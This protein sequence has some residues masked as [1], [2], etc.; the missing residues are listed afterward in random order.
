MRTY[1]MWRG[2]AREGGS[3]ASAR[4]NTPHPLAPILTW[5]DTAMGVLVTAEARV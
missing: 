2:A 5:S 4:T 1:I 3:K